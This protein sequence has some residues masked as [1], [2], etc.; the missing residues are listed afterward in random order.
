MVKYAF[1]AGGTAYKERWIQTKNPETAVFAD[2]AAANITRVT[3]NGYKTGT[4]GGLYK[5]NNGGYWVMNNG[6]NGN[7]WG[8]TPRITI[9]QGG[10]PGYGGTVTTTGYNDLYVRIDNVT[11][12]DVSNAKITSGNLY[13]AKNFIEK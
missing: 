13:Q 11:L 12:S 7:T 10:T 9:Y 3:G 4:W 1:T 2:V 6:T 8:S 5:L